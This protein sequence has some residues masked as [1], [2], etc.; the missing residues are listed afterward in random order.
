MSDTRR[1][2]SIEKV[3]KDTVRKLDD[4]RSTT[5]SRIATHTHTG[6]VGTFEYLILTDQTTGDQYF[7]YIDNGV[8]SASPV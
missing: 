3:V 4:T 2:D 7:L 1:F 8:I 6:G 5:L